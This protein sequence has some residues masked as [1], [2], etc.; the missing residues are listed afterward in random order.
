MARPGE[1]GTRAAPVRAEAELEAVEEG[2]A[3]ELEAN[4]ATR[5]DTGWAPRDAYQLVARIEGLLADHPERPALWDLLFEALERTGQQAALDAYRA[6]CADLQ[7]CTGLGPGPA[8]AALAVPALEPTAHRPSHARRCRRSVP[9]V[10]VAERA[11]P[12]RVAAGI[13]VP[14]L[15]RDAELEAIGHAIDRARGGEGNAL[16]IDGEGGIG[17]SRL[18]D[19]LARTAERRGLRVCA[20]AA[21]PL[22]RERPFAVLLEALG[23]GDLPGPPVADD[24][25]ALMASHGSD[26]AGGRFLA[27]EAILAAIETATEGGAPLVIAIDDVH[28]ADAASLAALWAIGRRLRDLPILLAL[29]LRP[30][31]RSPELAHVVEGLA[32]RGAR[33]L[34]PAALDPG[35]MVTLA[36]AM[37]GSEPGPRLRQQLGATTGNPFYVVELVR[38][39]D[40][41]G[42]LVADGDLVESRADGVPRSLEETLLRHLAATDAAT[43]QLLRAAAVL[44]ASFTIDDLAIVTGEPAVEVARTVQRGLASGLL[45]D[46]GARVDFAHD[47]IRE[48]VYRSIPPSVRTA[49]HLD[50]ARRLAA[51]GRP[52]EIVA[53]HYDLGA[54]PGD[55]EA[56]TWLER[57]AEQAAAVNPGAAA[58]LYG[59]AVA[60]SADP[61]DRAPLRLAWAQALAWAGRFPE[62]V[63]AARAG[64]LPPVPAGYESRFEAVIALTSLLQGDLASAAAA[65]DRVLTRGDLPEPGRSLARAQQALAHLSLQ[66][67]E[68]ARGHADAALGAATGDAPTITLALGVL[69]RCAAFACEWDD[70]IELGRRAVDASALDHD[71]LRAQPHAFLALALMNADRIPEAGAALEEGIE[72]SERIGS[73][74]V[75]DRLS[76]ILVFVRFFGGAWDDARVAATV[77]DDFGEDTPTR[78][79][80]AEAQAM[81]G[82]IAL[83]RG[84]HDAVPGALDAARSWDPGPGGEPF[85]RIW[86]LWLE[87]AWAETQGDASRAL[88]RYGKFFDGGPAAGNPLTCVYVGADLVRLALSLGDRP[89]AQSATVTLEAVAGRSGTPHATG[90]ALHARGMVDDDLDIL[91]GAVDASRECARPLDRLRALESAALALDRAGRRDEAVAMLGEAIE[92]SRGLGAVALERRLVAHLRRMGVTRG[93]KGPRERP[94]SGW[95]SLTPAEREVARL[96]GEGRTNPEIAATLYVSRRTVETHVSHIYDKLDVRGRVNLATE[97]RARLARR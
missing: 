96:V 35:A 57:A 56:V 41:E 90:V 69:C 36:A 6:A 1:T 20:A 73:P 28:R 74:W 92:T 43:E 72:R 46:A 93:A 8:L 17:K 27:Q 12:G 80:Q 76:T 82:L 83:H 39:L 3:A 64:L 42:L 30:E 70:A 44:G 16:V 78:F 79:G 38:A 34:R 45:T 13:E 89:R 14:L 9:R 10:L 26:P 21:D 15:E 59:R 19:E 29:A 65:Y 49:L 7:R 94:V 95:D 88:D 67:F 58:N 25:C 11:Y 37:V 32:G 63:S 52:A 23:G 4:C 22:E 71:A 75:A 18:L 51:T 61:A 2:L 86:P 68:V 50:A 62:A 87:G 5:D 66:D 85:E 55:H 84:E 77:A 53:R 97:A 24:V 60:L 81:L 33:V 91:L 31:D 48:V 47:L 40:R 54:V